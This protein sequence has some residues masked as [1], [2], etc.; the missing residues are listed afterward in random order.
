MTDPPYC[1]W[2]VY[3]NVARH[4]VQD[5]PWPVLPSCSLCRPDPTAR[6]YKFRLLALNTLVLPTCQTPPNLPQWD[7]VFPP[8][9][10]EE[11]QL[12][13]A[14]GLVVNQSLNTWQRGK[15]DVLITEH[16]A[17]NQDGW[18]TLTVRASCLGYG[19]KV[20]WRGRKFTGPDASG[21][22]TRWWTSDL[23]NALASFSP[24][25]LSIARL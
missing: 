3:R 1:N 13:T 21:Q 6:T 15:V 7:G 14:V 11:C 19:T 23:T 24:L 22:Y 17:G 9:G 18:M 8:N 20:V 5:G 2:P 16:T 10:K 25:Y 4:L 12:T